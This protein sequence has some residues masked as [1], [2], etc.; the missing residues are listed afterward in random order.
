L[1]LDGLTLPECVE[2]AV[3]AEALGYTDAWTS[4]ISGPDGFTLLG[5]IASRTT[6][7]RL[8]VA[9]APVYNRPPALLAMT[10]AGVHELSDGR[11]ALGLGSSTEAIVEGWMGQ[12]LERPVQRLTETVELLRLMFSGERVDYEGET[13]S[14]NRFR[15]NRPPMAEL[16]ILL[17]ALGPGMFRLAGQVADGLILHNASPESVLNLLRDLNA[18]LA[19]SG[20]DR[21]EVEVVFRVGVAINEDESTLFPMLRRDVAS[22]ASAR[23]YNRFFARQG[24]AAEAAAIE[25]AWAARD[26]RAAAE[27]VSERMLRALFI[28][29]SANECRGRLDAV[30]HAGVDTP[31]I[32]PISS[33]PDPATRNKRR[34]DTLK[35]LAA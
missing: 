16:P 9:I 35:I 6:S 22:Y 25:A 13:V 33:H 20:R 14:V 34:Q 30:R 19:S 21:S 2:L 28:T 17:G 15:L 26:G 7:L 23:P 24:F 29:G 1:P 10:A 18:G 27:A 31:V 8:G 12:K 11:F 3:W 32:I 5:A 4:E